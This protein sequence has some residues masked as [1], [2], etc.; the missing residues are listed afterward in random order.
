VVAVSKT[1]EGVIE[2]VE[3]GALKGQLLATMKAGDVQVTFDVIRDIMGFREG[4]KIRIVISDERPENLDRFEFCGHG[5]LV[6]EEDKS[7]V[8]LFSIWGIIFKF[9]P[10]IGL[11]PE[12]KYYLC[13][14]KLQ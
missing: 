3:E 6:D 11:K 12:K 13:I 9:A 4:D 5:Y 8:T 1:L 14:E 10:P 7:R 2:K